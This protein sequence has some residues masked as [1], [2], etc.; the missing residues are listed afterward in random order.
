MNRTEAVFN[1]K[2]GRGTPIL[3]I[4]I[5]NCLTT[6]VKTKNYSRRQSKYYLRGVIFVAGKYYPEIQ[7]NI[8]LRF[9]YGCKIDFGAF[10]NLQKINKCNFF[11]IISDGADR[12]NGSP[13]PEAIYVPPG[14]SI[15]V[16]MPG[17]HVFVGVLSRLPD[18]V[19]NLFVPIII[20]SPDKR[21]L[22]ALN[23]HTF[24]NNNN[25]HI[26]E[27][28]SYILLP[29]RTVLMAFMEPNFGMFNYTRSTVIILR[30]PEYNST[31]Y[32]GV[33]HVARGYRPHWLPLS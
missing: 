25:T 26:R 29:N 9:F 20:L 27:S 16:Q 13:P 22:C 18:N 24:H 17:D 7:V 30:I 32:S 4:N 1:F 3:G 10:S 28:R 15:Y 12:R 8:T 11:L 5:E 23:V 6:W 33:L 2:D 21:S 14:S 19:A 31:L